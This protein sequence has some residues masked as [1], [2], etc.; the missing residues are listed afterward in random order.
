M[1]AKFV[2]NLKKYRVAQELTQEQLADIVDV[3]RETIMS[4]QHP[5]VHDLCGAAD[6]KSCQRSGKGHTGRQRCAY[7]HKFKI[8]SVCSSFFFALLDK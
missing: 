5:A 1:E 7:R 4:V 8:H 6:W 3:R 2:C